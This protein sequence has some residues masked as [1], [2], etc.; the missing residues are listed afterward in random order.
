VAVVRPQ[1][2]H[3]AWLPVAALAAAIVVLALLAAAWL[4]FRASSAGSPDLAATTSRIVAEL[5]VLSLSLYTEQTVR[6]GQ[7]L[8]PEEYRAAGE[9]VQRARSQWELIRSDVD[10]GQRQPIDDLFEQLARAVETRAPA[11][12]VQRLVDDLQVRLRALG[13]GT[14]PL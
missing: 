11:S 10:P 2:K 5:D 3:P 4:R 12:E 1:R 6:D 8:S 13:E 9:A 7:I 14:S